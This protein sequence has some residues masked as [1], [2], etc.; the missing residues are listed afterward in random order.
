MTRNREIPDNWPAS[1]SSK[2][3]QFNGWQHTKSVSAAKRI[4]RP[5]SGAPSQESPPLV[6]GNP[7]PAQL[8]T[9]TVAPSP[10]SKGRWEFKQPLSLGWQ[11][12]A[13]LILLFSS[14]IGFTAV[15]LLLKLP[16]VPNCPATFWP[17]ASA[18]MRLYC[19]Q[20]AANK[21][22]GENLLEAI[23]LVEGLPKDHP[24]RP[25]INRHVE[26]WSLDIL[27]IGDKKFQE[28]QLSEAIKI[29]RRIPENVSAYKL[30]ENRI[31]RWQTIWSKAEA[32][33]E[34]AE[35]QLRESKW[36][37]AFREAV[38]LTSIN[39]KYWATAKYDQ[40]TNQIQIA[41]K[42]SEQL[43]K[44]YQLSKSGR[45]ADILAAIKQAEEIPSNSYAYKEAQELIADCGNKL[46]KLAMNRLEQRNWK[47][48]LEIANKIP[49]SVKLGEVKTD[50]IDLANALS[51]GESGTV[52]ELETAIATAQRLGSDRPLYDKAQEFIKRW[53]KE[54]EDIGRLE[55]ARAFAN[56][57]F[58]DDLKAAIAE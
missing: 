39:N 18:S 41:R 50:L 2:P 11:F 27:K 47:G 38:K 43:D 51:R 19:A 28:G 34:Q 9:P 52:S 14:G 53:Q 42:A 58:I 20:L 56:S 8:E 6:S 55:R 10:S 30:V 54:V 23:A 25:E 49:A 13:V 12:W 46:L 36:L 44:A 33:Y 5:A 40:L 29:A 35:N 48:V 7:P 22:T 37:Q 15:A 16:A 32:I 21:Q 24:L 31:D 17:T 45:I 3:G 1:K 4:V 26:E 57:G